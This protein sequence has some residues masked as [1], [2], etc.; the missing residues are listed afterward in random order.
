MCVFSYYYDCKARIL[1]KEN[2]EIINIIKKRIKYLYDEMRKLNQIYQ[3]CSSSKQSISD[4]CSLIKGDDVKGRY[5][6]NITLFENTQRNTKNLFIGVAEDINQLISIFVN[7][8]IGNDFSMS[9]RILTNDAPEPH[10]ESFFLYLEN[11]YKETLDEELL[12]EIISLQNSVKI[13]SYQTQLEIALILVKPKGSVNAE[14]SRL[15]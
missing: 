11:I 4:M 5:E 7:L 12:K 3:E 9:I 2:E 8:M 10:K 15:F 14:K 6:E 1:S 13:I